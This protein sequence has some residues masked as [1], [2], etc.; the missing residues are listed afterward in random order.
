ML[1]SLGSGHHHVDVAAAALGAHEP[2]APRGIRLRS[3][4]TSARD[5]GDRG[6]ARTRSYIAPRRHGTASKAAAHHCAS[7]WVSV[8][9]FSACGQR[10]SE[11]ANSRCHRQR[12]TVRERLGFSDR[13]ANQLVQSYRLFESA[14]FADLQSLQIGASALYLLARPSTPEEARAAS[15]KPQWNTSAKTS[16]VSQRYH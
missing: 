2:S 5:V 7:R 11:R 6:C 1:S 13:T 3:K 15:G 9:E 4:K 10:H 16:A 12:P 14:N 8:I